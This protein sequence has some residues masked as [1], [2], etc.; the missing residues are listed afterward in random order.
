VNRENA[1]RKMVSSIFFGF[2][3]SAEIRLLHKYFSGNTDV[4][5]AG[6]SLGIVSGHICSMLSPE[7]KIVVIEANPYLQDTIRKNVEQYR[8]K[9][10]SIKSSAIDYDSPQVSFSISSNNTE[11]SVSGGSSSTGTIC[12]VPAITLG[13]VLAEE[14][15]NEYALVSDIEGSEIS[16][17]VNDKEALRRCRQ[18]FIELHV[19]SYRNINYTVEDLVTLITDAGFRKIAN[20]GPVYYFERKD[21]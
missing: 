21:A 2:Y 18:I 16:F 1:N 17:L 19:T 11:S 12:T 15:I 5:E 14:A 9:G 20:E 10:Y 7:K 3:E 6:G 13:S 8:H 4:I